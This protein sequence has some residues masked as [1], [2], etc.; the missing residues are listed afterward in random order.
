MTNKEALQ[1]VVQVSLDDNVLVKALLDQAITSTDNYTAA[2]SS[3][4]DIAAIAVLEGLLSTPNI[5][6]GGYSVN[7]DRAAIQKRVDGLKRKA[8]IVTNGPFVRDAS[9]RW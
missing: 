3:S 6:E 4:I 5:S 1:A 7:Y 2:V 9:D 8:G